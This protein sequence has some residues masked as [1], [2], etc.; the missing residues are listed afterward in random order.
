MLFLKIFHKRSSRKK[1][2][3]IFFI[4]VINQFYCLNSS[5]L[6]DA[7]SNQ[8]FFAFFFLI[9]NSSFQQNVI[10]LKKIKKVKFY[11]SWLFF[12]KSFLIADNST[13]RYFSKKCF[14]SK[15]FSKKTFLCSDLCPALTISYLSC[16]AYLSKSFL[17]I[18]QCSPSRFCNCDFQ[19]SL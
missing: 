7:S 15:S 2:K 14:L 11:I 1:V 12:P 4:K 6:T 19:M 8:K 9:Y 3:P 16:W 18:V 13:W 10:L 17:W 5:N